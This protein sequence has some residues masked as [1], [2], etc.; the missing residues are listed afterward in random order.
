MRLGEECRTCLFNS[1][2][3]KVNKYEDSKK[4]EEFLSNLKTLCDTYPSNGASP[5]LMREINRLHEK[6][7]SF[8]LD[9]SKEKVKFNSICLI[10]SGHFQYISSNISFNLS[11][12]IFSL[13]IS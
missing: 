5:L 12:F 1:Q 9:Y 3:K 8:S 7:F 2:S 4:K 10:I 13:V 11:E 6:I